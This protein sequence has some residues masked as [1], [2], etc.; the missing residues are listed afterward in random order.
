MLNMAHCSVGF[1]ASRILNNTPAKPP[2]GWALTTGKTTT[3][4]KGR[5]NTAI[6]QQTKGLPKPL[7]H[8]DHRHSQYTINW[9]DST[10]FRRPYI[11][12]SPT[13]LLAS[14]SSRRW[15]GGG[16]RLIASIKAS[17]SQ[18]WG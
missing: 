17:R 6:A 12:L 13:L 4:E 2:F 18:K 11:K 16:S 14:A 1:D 5:S 15:S 8:H 9:P 10:R 7:L 3:L